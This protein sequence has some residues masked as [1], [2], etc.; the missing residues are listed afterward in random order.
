MALF[1]LSLFLFRFK[2]S[3]FFSFHFPSGALTPRA[4][5]FIFVQMIL[6]LLFSEF[7]S[8]TK[9]HTQELFM[10]ALDTDLLL[11]Y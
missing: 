9:S 10:D 6:L 4:I 3:F 1:S 11:Y 7:K 2:K 5:S 8:L